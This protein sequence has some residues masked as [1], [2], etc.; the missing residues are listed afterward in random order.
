MKSDPLYK[1]LNESQNTLT[2]E[3]LLHYKFC[4]EVKLVAATREYDIQISSSDVD[5]HGYDLVLD[6]GDSSRKIQL[7]SRMSG[8]ATKTFFLHPGLIRPTRETASQLD[9]PLDQS[10]VGDG[11]A[12]ICAYVSGQPILH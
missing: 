1:F 11:G 12:A 5:R 10:G 7:K 6:D 8:A 9:F 4:Y 3:K 2:R